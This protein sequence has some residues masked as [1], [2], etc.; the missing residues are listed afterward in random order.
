M[1]TWSEQDFERIFPDDDGVLDEL[2]PEQVSRLAVEP[3]QRSR[4]ASQLAYWWLRERRTGDA[5]ADWQ[6]L[7]AILAQALAWDPCC[8]EA[9]VTK[10]VIA[11]ELAELS[12]RVEAQ[13]LRGEAVSALERA[14]E[15]DEEGSE[16]WVQLGL[17]RY[18]EGNFERAQAAFQRALAVEPENAW[19]RLYVAHCFH[20][21]KSW[22]EA[23]L[24]YVRA[25][26]TPGIRA[27]P[28]WRLRKTLEQ[29][30]YCCANL[31]LEVIAKG[32]FDDLLAA[33]S[34]VQKDDV[35]LERGFA[36]P[37]ELVAAAK[38]GL[39]NGLRD[40]VDALVARMEW[41]GV[42]GSLKIN[43]RGLPI[44]AMTCAARRLSRV[45]FFV[46]VRGFMRVGQ[47]EKGH[48]RAQKV[49][50]NVSFTSAV[51]P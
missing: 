13:M 5:R 27:M 1:V 51:L 10:G 9:L 26:A 31:G 25:L 30:A 36:F 37:D 3:R 46:Q 38:N 40:D 2:W 7:G 15:L 35:L 23:L 32:L 28:S 14:T 6:M 8:V 20:D 21:Q 47:I 42:Y 17:A 11:R 41:D 39:V 19:A 4:A 22:N 33:L 18:D 49:F 24:E 29:I 45:R 12:P 50:A 44:E 43:G 48:G 34:T 16:A